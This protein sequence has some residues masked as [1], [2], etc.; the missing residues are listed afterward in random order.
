MMS[1]IR[2]IAC[3]H[4]ARQPKRTRPIRDEAQESFLS[5][6]GKPCGLV[7]GTDQPV[8]GERRYERIRWAM[9]GEDERVKWAE[10]QE[11]IPLDDSVPV[12]PTLMSA[13]R[14]GIVEIDNG[15]IFSD[16][17][18]IRDARGYEY[19]LDQR[20]YSWRTDCRV[21]VKEGELLSRKIKTRYPKLFSVVR[22]WDYSF[23]H[24][25]AH[26]IPKIVYWGKWLEERPDVLVLYM[27][28]L[29]K[30]CMKQFSRLPDSRF[31]RFKQSVAADKIYWPLFINLD[32][33]NA[34]VHPHNFHRPLKLHNR[35]PFRVLYAIRGKEVRFRRVEN[36]VAVVTELMEWSRRK[37]LEFSVFRATS[38]TED[39]NLV[40]QA[41]VLIGPHG[42]ALANCAFLPK[43]G[44][45][46]EIGGSVEHF[47]S[48]PCF[49]H[50]CMGLGLGHAMVTG[51]DFSFYKPDIA[52]DIKRLRS[53]LDSIRITV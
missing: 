17:G 39:R 11:V 21:I 22:L 34:I 7:V 44:I 16:N 8:P 53:V 10:W 4:Q 15:Y 33:P 6:G 20:F 2:A 18:L 35:R 19:G 32:K 50:I 42:G 9:P 40:N 14:A 1:H 12:D 24:A 48:R 28:E 26:A 27:T 52:V 3:L 45:C 49:K 47:K 31:V 51:S 30:W 23:S 36:E 41:V 29:Q 25:V 5:R 13:T 37:G 38:P 43:G 46:V